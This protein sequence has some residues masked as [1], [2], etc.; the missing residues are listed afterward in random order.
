MGRADFVDL[1]DQDQRIIHLRRLQAMNQ[2]SGHRAQVRAT[3]ALNLAHVVRSANRKLVVLASQRTRDALRDARLSRARRS[4]EAQHLSRNVALQLPH[5]DELQ[6][7]VL[8]V[9]QPVVVFVQHVLRLREIHLIGTQH[10]PGNPHHP[11][12]VVADDAELGALDV[13]VAQSRQFLLHRLRHTPIATPT[14]MAASD[15][16]RPFISSSCALILSM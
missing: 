3:V 8:H 5:G 13:R 1:V 14:E 16:C 7:A 4:H 10:V 6:D 2:L 9:L 12:D 11:V 15:T